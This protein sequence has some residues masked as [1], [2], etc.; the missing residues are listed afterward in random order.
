MVSSSALI[1]VVNTINIP[2]IFQVLTVLFVRS[3]FIETPL[4]YPGKNFAQ[5]AKPRG[6]ILVARRYIKVSTYS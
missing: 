6:G 2:E 4:Y 1:F 5:K 3:N